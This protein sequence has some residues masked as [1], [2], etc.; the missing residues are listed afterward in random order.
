MH[1]LVNKALETFLA[2]TFGRDRWQAIV[3]RSGLDLGDDG[4]DS[5]RL[6]EGWQA[7]ALLAAAVHVLDRSR[8]SLL[9]DLGTFLICNPGQDSVRR[10]MRFGGSSF[11]DFLLSLDDLPGRSRLAV[12]DLGLPDLTVIEDGP[13]RFLLECRRMPSGLPG[14]G[15]VCA[16]V[17]RA[18]ADDYGVLA[19][20]EH[21]GSVADPVTGQPPSGEVGGVPERRRV[22]VPVEVLSI[23]VHDPDYQPGRRFDL[24][25]AAG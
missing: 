12:P 17:L 16:G 5:M 10:L 15:H 11:S 8:E 23:V 22:S 20:I 19:V 6:Y 3:L 24:A 13:G 14:V 2:A 9:E 7:E 21:R 1:G 4:F 18:L 25:L